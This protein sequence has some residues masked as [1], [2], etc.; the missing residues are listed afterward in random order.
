M[1]VPAPS[2]WRANLLDPAMNRL[3]RPIDMFGSDMQVCRTHAFL[4]TGRIAQP[5]GTSDQVGVQLAQEP[6]RF[7]LASHR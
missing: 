7:F 3:N 4:Q 6:A 2:I 1:S 5:L